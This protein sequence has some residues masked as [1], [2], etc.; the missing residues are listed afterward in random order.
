MQYVQLTRNSH[1]GIFGFKKKCRCRVFF[2]FWYFSGNDVQKFRD[3]GSWKNYKHQS[4]PKILSLR[5]CIGCFDSLYLPD[6]IHDYSLT[7]ALND[8][9]FSPVRIDEVSAL[10]CTVSLLTNFEPARDCYDWSLET[11]GIRI[12]F[13]V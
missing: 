13:Y 1:P 12:K 4:K 9:R 11:H 6:G 7:A 3:M 5:G 2:G 8:S 10:S